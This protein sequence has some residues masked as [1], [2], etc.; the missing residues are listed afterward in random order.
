[1]KRLIIRFP[2]LQSLDLLAQLCRAWRWSIWISV[3]GIGLIQLVQIAID[4]FLNRFNRFG[5]TRF[6]EV[7]PPIVH[8]LELAAVNRH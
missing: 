8:R 2:L 5:Q 4:L 7:A 6:I 1:M 3:G